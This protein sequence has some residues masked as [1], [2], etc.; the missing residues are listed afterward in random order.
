[1]ASENTQQNTS[2]SQGLPQVPVTH[3]N[4]HSNNNNTN[5]NSINTQIGQNGGQHQQH[6]QKVGDF[7]KDFMKTQNFQ[8]FGSQQDFNANLNNGYGAGAH[9]YGS[10]GFGGTTG[11][12]DY[13]T[14]AAAAAFGAF[15][16]NLG[17]AGAGF[18]GLYGSGL[19][20][21]SAQLGFGGK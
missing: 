15:N 6:L 14:A 9:G 7:Q 12:A 10:T 21:L 20:G 2:T 4:N 16:L 13:S 3:E 17:A 8:N 1:M 19:D 18:P 11:G 5:N